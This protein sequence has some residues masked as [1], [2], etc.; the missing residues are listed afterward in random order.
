MGNI[1]LVLILLG[2]AFAFGRHHRAPV[3]DL[4]G[5]DDLVG[6]LREDQN[7]VSITPELTIVEGTGP[8][9]RYELSSETSTDIPF[10]FEITDKVTG[11]AKLKVKDGR[12][13]DCSTP[14]NHLFVYAVRCEDSAKSESVSLRVTVRDTNDHAP[15]FPKP[16]YTFNVDEGKLYP[17]IARIQATDKDCGHPYGQICRYEITNALNGFPFVIDEQGVLRNTEPL[18]YNQAKVYILTVV[19]H[20]CGMQK[21]KSTLITVNVR[22]ACKDGVRGV[23]ERINYGAGSG[24]KRIAPEASIET[25][26]QSKSCTVK[27]IESVVRLRLDHLTHGCD[28]NSIFSEHIHKKFVFL[29][30]SQ[31]SSQQYLTD[32]TFSKTY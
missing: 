28:R 15:E 2:A 10:E 13:L 14:Q 6:W 26:A 23:M 7:I 16:W 3:I 25:C 31:Y 29:F 9:C 1:S 27:S 4:G 24:A 30:Y 19:A 17:E 5:A 20:D 21:S 32:S 8:I 22:K 18:D 11:K 12:H